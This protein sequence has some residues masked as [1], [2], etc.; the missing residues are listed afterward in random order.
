MAKAA[1]PARAGRA[2]GRRLG[3]RGRARAIAVSETR[4]R[5]E[6]RSPPDPAQVRRYVFTETADHCGV[7]I[8]AQGGL[9]ADGVL[10]PRGVETPSTEGPGSIS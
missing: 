1:R 2:L 5:L 4:E 3:C 6:K 10:P 8:Q 9:W 7:E